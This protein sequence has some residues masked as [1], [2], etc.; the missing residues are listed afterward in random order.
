VAGHALPYIEFLD[1]NMAIIADGLPSHHRSWT[2]LWWKKNQPLTNASK[3][4]TCGYVA[5]NAGLR[6]EDAHGLYVH[7]FSGLS[8]AQSPVV[9]NYAAGRRSEIA[10]RGTL[11]YRWRESKSS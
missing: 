5:V 3:C 9:E 7:H 1:R 2:V 11:V 8:D 4:D 6:G 10:H